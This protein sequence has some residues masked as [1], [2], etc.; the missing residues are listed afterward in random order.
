[1]NENTPAR[2]S[3]GKF[4][5]RKLDFSK[6]L[7]IC[8]Y[9]E[10]GHEEIDELFA[11]SRTVP[12]V[13]TG[14]EKE[15]E[16]EHHLVEALAAHSHGKRVT[17]PI[18]EAS[19]EIDDYPS[20]YRA[21]FRQ[22]KYYIKCISKLDERISVPFNMSESDK[23]W[24]DS[25][26]GSRNDV[27]LSDLQFECMIYYLESTFSNSNVDNI[28][29]PIIDDISQIP[30]A[31]EVALSIPLME[32][33]FALVFEHWKLMKRQHKTLIPTIKME[34][35]PS[36]VS[37]KATTSSSAD[38]YLCFRRR[39][40]KAQR[41][42]R[43][44]ES[45]CIDKLRK[46]KLEMEKLMALLEMTIKRDKYKRESLILDSLIFE[47]MHQ[48]ELWKSKFD[49]KPTLNLPSMKAIS[50]VYG[51]T[52][53][54]SVREPKSTALLLENAYGA[55]GGNGVSLPPTKITIPTNLFK[56]NRNFVEFKQKYIRAH[57]S[58]LS[59]FFLNTLAT[60]PFEK[61]L[62]HTSKQGEKAAHYREVMRKVFHEMERKASVNAN[63]VDKSLHKPN[64]ELP[65]YS[66][67]VG[68]SRTIH[69]GKFTE[70]PG[71]T[72]S[73]DARSLL[74]AQFND[75]N[76]K[77]LGS[78]EILNLGNPNVY[79]I[80]SHYISCSSSQRHSFMCSFLPLPTGGHQTTIPPTG[81]TLPPTNIGQPFPIANPSIVQTSS[82]SVVPSN[83]SSPSG[84]TKHPLQEDVA[85]GNSLA[86]RQPFIE[87]E[88]HSLPNI[89]VKKRKRDS[90]ASVQSEQ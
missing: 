80:N 71:I 30:F 82:S 23:E 77:V 45:V 61:H 46:L 78:Q 10:L 3:N 58:I 65:L 5:S 54:I 21:N 72:V 26:N 41:K 88:S 40:V 12:S 6:P 60:V 8:K 25:I 44:S 35:Y 59:D 33:F 48:F 76:S 29:I 24:L 64:P 9:N 73:P 55:E 1:M 69:Q 89:S 20:L 4:R 13:A 56:A 53:G 18:P 67:R 75:L 90:N 81:A 15:E 87:I 62:I 43:K 52:S 14:V 50:D 79:N 47:K 28:S 31:A 42:T 68:R 22:A 83:T 38:P 57:S 74:A 16:K 7:R 34:E 11:I 51:Y 37:A 32:V 85:K 63:F 27:K 17:I 19:T 84:G 49:I 36:I 66:I 70:S 86:N 2:G 39:E